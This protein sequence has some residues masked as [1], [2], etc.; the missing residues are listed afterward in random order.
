M[1]QKSARSQLS[2]RASVFVKDLRPSQSD[3]G[4]YKYPE[5]PK[6]IQKDEA[7][8]GMENITTATF[9]TDGKR[10]T[11]MEQSIREKLS[12]DWKN[13]YRRLNAND[14]TNTGKV[15]MN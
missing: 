10:N 5:R 12:Y 9:R 14:L 6:T 13:I 4:L 8:G 7:Y 11:K 15:S 1:D 2:Q 3:T